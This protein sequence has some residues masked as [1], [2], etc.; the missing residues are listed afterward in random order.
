MKRQTN[1]PVV[2]K[3]AVRS[4][5]IESRLKE[6]DALSAH[7]QNLHYDEDTIPHGQCLDPLRC[8]C[9]CDGVCGTAKRQAAI[10][11][12]ILIRQLSKEP[13]A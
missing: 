7:H 10:Q 9:C 11:A 4:A 1:T 5:L 8:D 13:K 2:S 6:Q 12:A 3:R